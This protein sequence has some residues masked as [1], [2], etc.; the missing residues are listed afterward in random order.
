LLLRVVVEKIPDA[1][2]SAEGTS[3]W[4]TDRV[5]W[6]DWLRQNYVHQWLL[7]G[8]VHTGG[9]HYTS[10]LCPRKGSPTL[11]MVTWRRITNF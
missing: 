6:T 7:I 2:H 9:M 8:P 4:W 1:E 10:T 3:A 5:H 11:L